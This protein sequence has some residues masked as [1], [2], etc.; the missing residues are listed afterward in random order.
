MSAP[1]NV[2]QLLAA[3]CH[4][5][6]TAFNQLVPLVHDE[7]R[8][9]ARHYMRGE[10]VNH[11]LQPTALVNEAYLR[12]IDYR[13]V[14]WRNRAHFIA[15]ASQAMRHLLVDHARTKRREKR[16]GGRI[17]VTLDEAATQ[18]AERSAEVVALDEALARLFTIDERKSRVVELRY[19]GG[20]SNEEIA[21]VL[22]VSVNTVVRDWSL[23]RAWLRREMSG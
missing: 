21:E 7:L 2:T 9:V 3:W 4:G 11:T 17:F 22:K 5:D 14:E 13:H 19:F 20:L 23:A 10:R 6:Q 16:G 1:A 18:A 15:I 8:R 12:L